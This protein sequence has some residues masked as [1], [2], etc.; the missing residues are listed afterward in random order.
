[1]PLRTVFN[2]PKE[3]GCLSEQSLSPKGAR[4][5]LRTVFKVRKG[6]RSLSGLLLMSEREPEASRDTIPVS[7]LV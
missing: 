7:L 5:P 3:P 2:V 1:M 6:A 4:M